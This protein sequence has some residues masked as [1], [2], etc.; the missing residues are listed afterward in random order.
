MPLRWINIH[1]ALIAAGSTLADV[2]GIVYLYELNISFSSIFL[3]YG[4][5]QLL[6]LLIRPLIV[7][8]A[9]RLGLKKSLIIGTLLSAGTYL[10]LSQVH[11]ISTWLGVF[12]VWSAI[13]EAMYWTSY[14][15]YFA[16]LSTE[17][18]RGENIGTKEALVT[19]VKAFAPAASGLAI[20]HFGFSMS[21]ALASVFVILAAIPLLFLP[22]IDTIQPP[23]FKEAWGSSDKRGFLAHFGNG[24]YGAGLATWSLIVFLLVTDYAIA[25]GLASL[26]IVF[27]VIAF[28]LIGRFIDRGHGRLIA[29]TALGLLAIVILGRIGLARDIPI[30]ILFDIIYAV[31]NCFYGPILDTILYNST[32]TAKSAWGFQL[33]SEASVDVGYLLSWVFGA[34]VTYFGA[35]L[36]WMLAWSLGGIV[37][38]LFVFRN[39]YSNRLEH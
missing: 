1:F 20:I 29:H 11:G 33:V 5:I 31:A 15:V 37:V 30:I 9:A 13:S 16:T 17:N 23:S 28:L 18:K 3:V 7:K 32:A 27:Q 4:G 36:Y 22:A 35:S 21:F 14:H 10:I 6:R 26:V 2:F 24:L 19:V 38:M 34:V 39:Y 12:I 25:G 8:W